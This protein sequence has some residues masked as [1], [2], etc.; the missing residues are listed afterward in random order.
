MN[1]RTKIVATLGPASD[2]PDVLDAMLLAGV[3]VVRLNLSHGPLDEH[4]AR[5]RAVR[6]AATRTGSVVA[7]LADLPGPK[8]R[9]AAFP[10][11][12]RRAA[13]RRRRSRMVPGRHASSSQRRD[14][15]RL[16]DAARRSSLRRPD[17]PRRR[18]DHPWRRADHRSGR[19]VSGSQRRSRAGS[20]RRA[21]AVGTAPVPDAD[22]RRPGA[23]RGDGRARASTSS[24]SRSFERA[25]DLRKVASLSGTADHS[26]GRQDR[27]ARRRSTIS[28]RSSP[29]PTR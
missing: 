21:P 27:D 12:G 8:V 19:R 7:V 20:T 18:R 25:D 5:L 10:D 2:P 9:A 13:R 14:R 15:R 11:G 3:D 16:P 23:G 24:P 29:C 1:A 26:I 22:R 4:I 17:R 28:T 6:E